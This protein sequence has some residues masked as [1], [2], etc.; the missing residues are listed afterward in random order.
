M[1]LP[2]FHPSEGY[3][4]VIAEA[5]AHALPVITTSWLAIPE[6]VDESCGILIQARDTGAFVRAITDLHRDRSRWLRMKDGARDRAKDFDHAHWAARFA[7]LCEQL[8]ER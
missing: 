7:A 8:T 2:T 4:G 6:I 1:L 3:P 5:Y